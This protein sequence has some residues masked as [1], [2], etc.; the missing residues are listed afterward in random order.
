VFGNTSKIGSEITKIG[1]DKSI[2]ILIY[3]LEA[4][5]EEMGVNIWNYKNMRNDFFRDRRRQNW[6]F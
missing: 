3:I 6:G 1:D 5:I 4:D 2:T